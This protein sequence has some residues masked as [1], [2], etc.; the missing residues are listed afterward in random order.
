MS[1]QH[2]QVMMPPPAL[3]LGGLLMGYGLD[4]AL[5]LPGV[6]FTGQQWVTLV[7]ALIGIGL[8]ASAVI[9]LRRAH[10][11]L[12]PHRAANALLTGGVFS[13]SRNPIYLGFACLHLAMALAQHSTGMLV[14]WVPVIWV[15]QQH[16][17][18]AEE[19]FH[20]QQFGEQWQAYRKKVRRWL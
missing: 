8:A 7:L 14:M 16:V 12:M 18:A 13:L 6:H 20:A 17:I 5:S 19:T 3:F 15:I 1:L 2:P 4:R 11:T 10:T 9:Q